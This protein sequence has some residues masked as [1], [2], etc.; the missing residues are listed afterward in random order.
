MSVNALRPRV[1]VADDHPLFATALQQAL[2]PQCEV[3]GL[4]HDGGEVPEAAFKLK[5]D[6]VTLDLSMPHL[7]G[8]RLIRETRQ[9]AKG[10]RILVVN[11]AASRRLA[12]ASLAEGA[13]GF[14]AKTVQ[15]TQ[16][17]KAAKTVLS[18]RPCVI[19]GPT[20]AQVAERE[21][22][23]NPAISK[24]SRRYRQVLL[25]I[26]RELTAPQI[27]ARLKISERTVEYYRAQLK[28][29]LGVKTLAGL[30]RLAAEFAE[31]PDAAEAEH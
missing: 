1:L 7:A 10:C 28:L 17:R 9:A 19:L 26:G 5:A 3:V 25:L 12:A 4:L 16:V 24:L 15:P 2:E 27:A 14:V 22:V 21:H 31:S 30:W 11:G 20:E 6:L 29:R 13:N 8:M 23:R 18:G